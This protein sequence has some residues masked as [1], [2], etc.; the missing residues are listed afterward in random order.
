MVRKTQFAFLLFLR[1]TC[2]LM[3]AALGSN[4]YACPRKHSSIGTSATAIIRWWLLFRI[5]MQWM[6]NDFILQGILYVFPWHA[7]T[8]DKARQDKSSH[9]K[10]YC[11][12]LNRKPKR[13]PIWYMLCSQPN[14]SFFFVHFAKQPSRVWFICAKL[15]LCGF[16]FGS[17]AQRATRYSN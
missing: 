17:R 16:H 6:S 5:C 12:K 13:K 3:A 11:A 15:F 1:K 8:R 4:G 2:V 9:T 14:Q 7:T 10:A